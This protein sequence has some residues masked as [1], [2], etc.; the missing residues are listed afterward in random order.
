MELQ[1]IYKG[2]DIDWVGRWFTISRERGFNTIATLGKID[3]KTNHVEYFRFCHSETD[4]AGG[5]LKW[6]QDQGYDIDKLPPSG[7]RAEPSF[8][9]RI[10]AI[11]NAFRSSKKKS[12]KW[13]YYNATCDGPNIN[14]EI[15]W[16]VFGPSEV[17]RLTKYVKSKKLSHNSYLL[18]KFNGMILPRF[19]DCNDT[20]EWLFPANMRTT[21]SKLNE[22]ANQSSAINITTDIYTT[23]EDVHYQIKQCLTDNVHWGNWYL[24][25]IGKIVGMCGMRLLAG[26]GKKPN[27]HFG[28]FSNVGFMQ[29]PGLKEE[30]LNRD[31]AYIGAPP[32]TVKYP[33]SV[34]VIGWNDNMTITLKIHPC[35]CPNRMLP[36]KILN[37]IKQSILKDIK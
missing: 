9:K 20:G 13:R 7:T 24:A 4:A 5:M 26:N 2:R 29:T 33:I 15:H 10:V 35:I 21:D 27:M 25:N 1:K 17:E 16:I 11:I 31:E 30:E 34:A 8:F 14:N 12:I 28:T 22:F 3:L 23:G 36:P 6:L 37:E 32:G 18:T 19:L